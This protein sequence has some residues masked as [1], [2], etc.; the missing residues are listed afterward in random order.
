M[1]QKVL[2][3]AWRLADSGISISEDY[4]LPTRQARK[5]LIEFGKA[6]NSPY[7]LRYKKL[8]VNKKCYSYNHADDTV[9]E[10]PGMFAQFN[11]SGADTAAAS[12]PTHAAD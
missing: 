10:L 8:Y 7:K 9:F 4:S 1:K 12:S 6:Q 11:A 2:L 3:S 5:K